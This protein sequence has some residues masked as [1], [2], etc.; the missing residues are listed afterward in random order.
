MAPTSQIIQHCLSSKSQR[1]Y[2]PLLQK[3]SN[4]KLL[5]LRHKFCFVIANRVTVWLKKKTL[6]NCT[7]GLSQDTWTPQISQQATR[8]LSFGVVSSHSS[9]ACSKLIYNIT[10]WNHRNWNIRYIPLILRKI[11]KEFPQKPS[12]KSLIVT[13][14]YL[15]LFKEMLPCIFVISPEEN[16]WTVTCFLLVSLFGEP[17]EATKHLDVWCLSTSFKYFLFKV[18]SIINLA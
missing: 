17:G 1:Y 3:R 10:Y 12:N 7:V 18:L 11:W 13:L 14:N 15:G 4:K 9:D 8:G 16:T 2:Y 6:R 5:A